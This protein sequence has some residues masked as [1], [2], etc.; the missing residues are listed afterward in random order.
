MKFKRYPANIARF[1][2]LSVDGNEFRMN[3]ERA[4]EGTEYVLDTNVIWFF[5]NPSDVEDNKLQGN[6]VMYFGRRFV[7][8]NIRKALQDIAELSPGVKITRAHQY[9]LDVAICSEL[10]VDYERVRGTLSDVFSDVGTKSENRNLSKE[11]LAA[12]IVDALKE[13]FREDFKIVS[14]IIDG[15]P[16]KHGGFPS[17]IAEIKPAPLEHAKLAALADFLNVVLTFGAGR[18]R[19]SVRNDIR[20]I[21]DIISENYARKRLGRRPSLVFLT[22]DQRLLEACRVAKWLKLPFAEHLLVENC[23]SFWLW[24]RDPAAVF[25]AGT[26]PSR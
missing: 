11:Q 2:A 14:D 16:K 13:R 17:E 6:E 22:L 20:A 8:G 15:K 19:F 10:Q 1:A 21:S 25:A 9:E 23:Q 5:Q 4:V 7:A 24:R 12:K 3:L 18:S 26:P